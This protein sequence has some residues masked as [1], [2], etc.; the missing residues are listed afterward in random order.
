MFEK[1]KAGVDL[2][3]KGSEVANVEAWKNGQITGAVVGGVLI[4]G[5]N[6]AHAFGYNLPIDMDAA[7]TIGAGVVMLAHVVLTC[8]TS[9]RAGLL[10]A[11]EPA[12][13]PTGI[14]TSIKHVPSID[15]ETI[16]RGEAYVSGLSGAA[17]A[18]PI[19]TPGI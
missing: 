5:A 18:S 6:L 10:P 13:V 16:K 7:N 8:I 11:A 14:P 2:F 17:P 9:K 4:A 19:D 15:A 1:L 3:R 12:V